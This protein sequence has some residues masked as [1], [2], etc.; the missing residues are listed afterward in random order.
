MNFN[1]HQTGDAA[2]NQVLWGGDT[3]EPQTTFTPT[4][5]GMSA[6]STRILVAAANRTPNFP[7]TRDGK[8]LLTTIDK[9]RILPDLGY[10]VTLSSSISDVDGTP[11]FVRFLV[12]RPERTHRC[13]RTGETV[14]ELSTTYTVDL[15][16]DGRSVT[17]ADCANPDGPCPMFLRAGTCCHT[18]YACLVTEKTLRQRAEAAAVRSARV[19]MVVAGNGG[20]R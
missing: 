2:T 16:T 6:F 9:G 1:T 5:E 17:S 14:R 4:F 10:T 15:T 13:R 12:T 20:L 3:V 7:Q 18:E 19:S 11:L 8:A